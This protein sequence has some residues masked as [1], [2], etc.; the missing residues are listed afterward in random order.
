M[1]GVYTV[2]RKSGTAVYVSYVP[3]GRAQ[4]RE[5]VELVA[6]GPEFA[7]RLRE[8]K[9]RARDVLFKRK[10]A[11]VE[12]TFDLPRSRRALTFAQFV[13]RIYAGELRDRQL[14]TAEAEIEHM[15]RWPLG[16]HF[17]AM[18]LRNIDEWKVR[19]FV[20]ARREGRIGRAVGAGTINR[21]LARLSNLWNSAKRRGLVTGDNPVAAVA[22]LREPRHGV[23]YLT[24]DE[25]ARLLAELSPA[26]RAIVEVALHTG[27]RRGALFG[28]RWR[29]VDFATGL[30]R[31]PEDLS[32]SR[33]PYYV[34]MNARI[35]PVMVAQ[36]PTVIPDPHALVFPKRDG[37]QRK[38]V[39][40]AFNS[41][42]ERADIEHFR[43][44][45]LRHTAASR[46]VQNGGTLLD[47]A[48][49]LGHRTL[50]MTQR[51]AHLAPGNMERTAALTMLPR[52]ATKLVRLSAEQE[53]HR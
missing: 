18:Q 27:I 53:Q 32:K 46:I 6:R 4:V 50:A 51:Y 21:D 41:A 9:A 7:Q 42:C 17:A 39:R 25:E 19:G 45:D 20:K 26:L 52:D 23:R 29:D 49:H 8:A 10:A 2:D 11:I 16:R 5:R 13:E 31:I 44:H 12:G 48:Q 43:F 38:D 24:P 22:R 35:R 1:K 37:T 33:E 14:R 36:R 47:A 40:N 30:I 3:P 15:T 34:P 28:L